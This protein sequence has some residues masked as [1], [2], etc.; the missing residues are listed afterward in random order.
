MPDVQKCTDPAMAAI[1][2]SSTDEDI[3]DEDATHPSITCHCRANGRCCAP[4]HRLMEVLSVLLD[5]RGQ[6]DEVG[7]APLYPTQAKQNLA[8][9]YHAMKFIHLMVQAR[10]RTRTLTGTG[11]HTN[12][13]IAV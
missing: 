7:L 9:R 10:A 4:R 3:F 6:H 11:T 12:T 2:Y 13:H 8:M 5:Q 1:E